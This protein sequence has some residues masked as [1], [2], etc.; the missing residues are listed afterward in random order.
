MK[1]DGPKKGGGDDGRVLQLSSINTC[2]S[3]KKGPELSE[4][5]L[6]PEQER[7]RQAAEI[8]HRRLCKSIG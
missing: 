3:G 8:Y 1:K 2:P 6:Y 7:S 5:T 4:I